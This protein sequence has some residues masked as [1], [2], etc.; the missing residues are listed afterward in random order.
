VNET[1]RFSWWMMRNGFATGHGDT[2]EDLE[3][4]ATGEVTRLHE[5]LETMRKNC[6]EECEFVRADAARQLKE[7]KQEIER[8]KKLHQVGLEGEYQ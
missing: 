8:A 4:Q 3:A 2:I 5:M 1:E 7:M 6:M